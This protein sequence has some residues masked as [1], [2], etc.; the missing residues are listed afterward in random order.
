MFG[1][2]CL[3]RLHFASIVPSK[4]RDPVHFGPWKS[5][6]RIACFWIFLH[7]LQSASNLLEIAQIHRKTPI[8]SLKS[9]IL[10]LFSS[11]KPSFWS[12]LVKFTKKPCTR[13]E[14]FCT[15]TMKMDDQPAI[16]IA[17]GY[18]AP[19]FAHY[20]CNL[21][22]KTRENDSF[23]IFFRV[24]FVVFQNNVNFFKTNNTMH[25]SKAARFIF[26]WKLL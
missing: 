19:S 22:C 7:L 9:A 18:F 21:H 4:Q 16:P 1:P 17:G 25:R 5:C 3:F 10:A 12:F 14:Y 15:K 11:K 24:I 20:F 26:W 23:L 8:F 2:I 6:A 13:L